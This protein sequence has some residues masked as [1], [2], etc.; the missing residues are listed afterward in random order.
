MIAE[1]KN[2][3]QSI[4]IPIGSVSLLG[5]RTVKEGLQGVVVI[6]H[7]SGVGGIAREIDMSQKSCKM[8]VWLPN[9]LTS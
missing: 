2:H 3:N 6:A 7:G 1:D 9:Y 4:Q 5:D 8:Q